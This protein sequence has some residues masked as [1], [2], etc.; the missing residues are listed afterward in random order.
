MTGRAFD[1]DSDWDGPEWAAPVRAERLASRP[2]ARHGAAD[3]PLAYYASGIIDGPAYQEYR[4]I[5]TAFARANR[6]RGVPRPT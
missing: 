5:E 2:R 6:A 1:S 4:R 3:P